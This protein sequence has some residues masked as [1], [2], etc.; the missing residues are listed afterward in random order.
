MYLFFQAEDGIQVLVQSRGLEDVYTRQYPN[1]WPG[2]EP[3]FDRIAIYVPDMDSVTVDGVEVEPQPGNFYGG[4]ITPDVVG[5]FKG[6]P[7][8]MGW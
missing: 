7:G 4:W 5:P 2:F 6:I 3:I 8:S 1:P